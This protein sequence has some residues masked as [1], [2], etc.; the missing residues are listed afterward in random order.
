MGVGRTEHAR[1]GRFG[2]RIAQTT[3]NGCFKHLDA[4]RSRFKASSVGEKRRRRPEGF[5]GG[6]GRIVVKREFSSVGVIWNLRT[7][8]SFPQ[9]I[10][11]V[12]FRSRVAKSSL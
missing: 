2:S 10:I 12:S 9:T 1:N 6:I 5:R 7:L 8:L 3:T 4:D 11:L